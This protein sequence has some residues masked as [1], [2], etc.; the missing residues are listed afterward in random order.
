MYCK[1]KRSVSID[2]SEK[3]NNSNPNKS[4]GRVIFLLTQKLQKNS[5]TKLVTTTNFGLNNSLPNIPV[6]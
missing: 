3:M 5:Y 4:G 6:S 1:K 2:V